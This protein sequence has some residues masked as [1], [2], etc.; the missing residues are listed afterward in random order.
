[1]IVILNL[2]LRKLSCVSYL[3]GSILTNFHFI[4]VKYYQYIIFI[5]SVILGVLI[6]VLFIVVNLDT[7]SITL[8]IFYAPPAQQAMD[9]LCFLVVRLSVHL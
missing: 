7:F 4:L 3:C 2:N 5:F 8:S 6:R 1:M 9:A